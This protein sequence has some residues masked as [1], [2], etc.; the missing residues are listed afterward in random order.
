MKRV[1][2]PTDFSSNA[3]N[4]IVYALELYKHVPCTFYLVHTYGIPIYGMEYNM[5]DPYEMDFLD[6]Y[7][8][9]KKERLNALREELKASHAN[10]MHKFIVHTAFNTL[11]DEVRQLVAKKGVQ[12]IVMG[13]KGATGANKVWFGSNTVHVIKKS[14]CPVLAIP[15]NFH[16]EKPKE[17]LFP[18]DYEA[19][20][21]EEVLGELLFL[22][23]NNIGCINVLHVST[24]YDL[25]DAQVKNKVILEKL[26]EPHSHIFHEV[27]TNEVIKGINDFQLKTKINLLAM[28]RNKHSFL[29][30]LFIKPLVRKI[31]L[32]LEIPFMVMPQVPK[33]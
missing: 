5:I 20:Y 24:G 7:Q 23:E 1:L 9:E 4:A 33:N 17:I 14:T 31:A 30:S 26:L 28:V 2:L 19:D 21:K 25:N 13:T 6:H 10:P 27:S 3:H 29:E 16:Y 15:E 12:M 18:T 22:A 11:E 8:K 32:H